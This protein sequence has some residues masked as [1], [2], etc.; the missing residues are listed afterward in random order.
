[1]K[2]L[3]E[4][5]FEFGGVRCDEKHIRLM[6]MPKRP[7]PAHQGEKIEVPGRDGFLWKSNRSARSGMEIAVECSTLEG[8]SPDELAAWLRGDG[9]L[10]FSDEP[11]RAYRAHVIEEF[12]RE[13]MFLRFDRQRFT[14]QFSCQPHRYIYP[15]ADAET[16]TA[17]GV[18]ENPG[19]TWSLPR[20]T[21]EGSGDMTVYVGAYQI[22]ISGG[23]VIV[24]SE[25]M[26]CFE[27]DGITL[28][29]HRVTMDEFPRLL[30]M[31]NAVSWTGD[32][33]KVTVEGRWRCV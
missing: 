30:P 27:P 5:W 9:L 31:G 33:T 25:M 26:D 10:R 15:A 24:D 32:V 22:D 28:A 16:L 17:P 14:V 23:S 20:I 13:S 19:N 7:I 12:V 4:A 29:N 6:A 18:I 21:V 8:F 1:M 3:T 2:R 11:D